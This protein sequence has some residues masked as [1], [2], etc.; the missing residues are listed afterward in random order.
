MFP[1]QESITNVVVH[2]YQTRKRK[3]N[4]WLWVTKN[5]KSVAFENLPTEEKTKRILS[6]LVDENSVESALKGEK[7]GEE[8]VE[9]RPELVPMV[10]LEFND[11]PGDKLV[12]FFR[13]TIKECFSEEGWQSVINMMNAKQAKQEWSCKYCKCPFLNGQVHIRCDGCLSWVHMNCAG[14]KRKPKNGQ[15]WFCDAC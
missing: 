11:E 13:N 10:L 14:R 1:S 4:V 15:F 7:L 8:T 5:N 9:T 12:E 6:W 3:D 2:F